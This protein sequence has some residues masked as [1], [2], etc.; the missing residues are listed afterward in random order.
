MKLFNAV[1]QL[2]IKPI[3][4]ACAI[5]DQARP[6]RSLTFFLLHMQLRNLMPPSFTRS[7]VAADHPPIFVIRPPF[8]N[9]AN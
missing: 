6:Y 8:S 2:V 1:G 7:S 4:T 9:A 5:T 3:P